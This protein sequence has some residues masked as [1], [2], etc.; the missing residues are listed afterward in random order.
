MSGCHS[1]DAGIGENGWRRSPD[2]SSF[3]TTP[4]ALSAPSASVARGGTQG[5]RSGQR[6]TAS[7]RDRPAARAAGDRGART[8]AQP[9]RPRPLRHARS[10]AAAASISW[11][12]AALIAA[13]LASSS[14]DAGEHRRRD[15]RV[16][17]AL[18]DRACLPPFSAGRDRPPAASTTAYALSKT[19]AAGR[20]ARQDRAPGQGDEQVQLIACDTT[21]ANPRQ[22]LDRRRRSA[23]RL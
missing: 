9:S 14:H 1:L 8:Q 5:A 17:S 15:R 12:R 7:R 3:L 6:V 11:P 23:Q 10:A 16:G 4:S 20:S 19:P 2:F 18:R 21:R 13:Q 22:H